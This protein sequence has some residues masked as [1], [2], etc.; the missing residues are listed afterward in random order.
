MKKRDFLA[1]MCCG[2]FIAR[3][4]ELDLSKISQII[5]VALIVLALFKQKYCSPALA[6]IFLSLLFAEY[7]KI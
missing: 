3:A 6:K 7:L 2:V 5:T 4:S 1:G